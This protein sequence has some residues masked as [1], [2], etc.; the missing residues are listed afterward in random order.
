MNLI[1]FRNPVGEGEGGGEK[2]RSGI[3]RNRILR[4][5]ERRG[6]GEETGEGETGEGGNCKDCCKN[7]YDHVFIKN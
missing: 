6:G 1:Y 5:R 4:R 7:Y 2:R 3:S